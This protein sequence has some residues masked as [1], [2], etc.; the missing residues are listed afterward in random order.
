MSSAPQKFP[1]VSIIMPTLNAGA[2]LE[3]CLARLE[4]S[5][6]RELVGPSAKW[7]DSALA[8][9][10][11]QTLRVLP[12]LSDAIAASYFAHSAISRTGRDNIL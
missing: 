12:Q 2:V 7:P 1:R 5:D 4:R 8:A 6:A 9:T 3:N 10:I 11:R